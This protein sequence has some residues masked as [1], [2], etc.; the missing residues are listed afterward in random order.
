MKTRVQANHC[1]N[2]GVCARIC[3]EVFELGDNNAHVIVDE[4]PPELEEAVQ[5]AANSCPPEA[6]V[7][8]ED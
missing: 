1:I 6:I 2:S 8:D 3:P 7:I 5:E 4:V